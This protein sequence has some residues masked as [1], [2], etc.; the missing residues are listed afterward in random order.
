V[1]VRAKLDRAPAADGRRARADAAR[2][3]RLV[4][5]TEIRR[6]DYEATGAIPQDSEDLI[7][8]IRSVAGVEVG[9]LFMEQR[10][11]A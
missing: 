6:G 8:Y 4:A 7:N 11:A 10:A 3:K 1:P 5:H 9:L 2:A